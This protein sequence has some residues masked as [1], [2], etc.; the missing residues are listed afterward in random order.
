M[1]S[2]KECDIYA[3]K[4]AQRFDEF[5]KW[6]IENWPNKEFPLVASD[7]SESRRELGEILGPKLSEGEDA[8]PEKQN[9]NDS[10]QYVNVNPMPWP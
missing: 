5:T 6:A 3:A 2:K 1:A 4:V 10:G 7:F 9:E 8:A